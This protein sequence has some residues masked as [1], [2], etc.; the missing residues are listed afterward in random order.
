EVVAA[1]L[2]GGNIDAVDIETRGGWRFGRQKNA[3]NVARNSEVMIEAFFLVRLRID[4]GVVERE[5]RLLGD[6]FKNYK[7]TLRKPLTISTVR[8]TEHTHV[9][10]AVLKRANHH[11]ADTQG[12]IPQLCEFWSLGQFSQTDR[13]S[14]LP[15]PA[16][17]SFAHSD[18]VKPY[19]TFECSGS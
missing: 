13:L 10:S 8:D 18:A 5:S 15:N 17:Q 7:I 2:V 3:L 4:D 9:L 6:R 16:E 1:H 19:I 14:G 12:S 11:R